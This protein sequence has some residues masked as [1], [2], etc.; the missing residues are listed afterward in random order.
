MRTRCHVQILRDDL[1][2][3][4]DR[5]TAQCTTG[6]FFSKRGKEDDAYERF[7]ES[8]ASSYHDCV[9]CELLLDEMDDI[10]QAKRS[11][12]EEYRRYVPR[13][14]DDATELSDPAGAYDGIYFDIKNM[15]IALQLPENGGAV[16]RHHSDGLGTKTRFGKDLYE[17]ESLTP[18]IH[19]YR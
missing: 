19:R 1:Y 18:L 13:V 11:F 3:A 5:S 6:N 4:D 9:H 2:A 10:R 16:S 15:S 14:A 17:I 7:L 12:V 8:M